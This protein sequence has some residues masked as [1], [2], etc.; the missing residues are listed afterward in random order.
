MK[1]I[2]GLNLS[3]LCSSPTHSLAC[4]W[5]PT[6]HSIFAP[7]LREGSHIKRA[8]HKTENAAFWK[9]TRLFEAAVVKINAMQPRPRFIIVCGDLIHAFPHQPQYGTAQ[10]KGER[11]GERERR[12]ERGVNRKKKGD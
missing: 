4:L 9:E 1:R 6:S 5:V 11:E 3:S 2:L 10:V 8:E 7:S 12:T